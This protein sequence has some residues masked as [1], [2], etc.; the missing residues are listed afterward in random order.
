VTGVQTC[1]LP[2]WI[3]AADNRDPRGYVLLREAIW[4]TI[5]RSPPQQRGRTPLPPPPQ[6]RLININALQQ[7]GDHA[8]VVAAIE[9]G[10]A[11]APFWLDAHCLAATS[12]QVLGVAFEPARLAVVASVSSFVR[13]LPDLIDLAF[14]DG[15]PFAGEA[16]RQWLAENGGGGG[17]A[18]TA[19]HAV[20]G[21]E[22]PWVSASREAR[23]HARAGQTKEGVVVLARGVA[24]APSARERFLWQTA[25]AEYCLDLGMV[26][27]ALALLDHLDSVIDHY[28]VEDWEPNLAVRVSGLMHQCLMHADAR[29]LRPDEVRLPQLEAHRT[30]LCRLDMVAAAGALNL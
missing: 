24:A 12:L 3:R 20:N 18:G 15:T 4:C 14:T 22:F 21:A 6:D 16:T 2:I 11:S 23:E 19:D 28:N 25:Q 7:G 27:P 10:L 29:A 13:R 9:D 8:A 17:A 5:A 26:A 1:A 30:R